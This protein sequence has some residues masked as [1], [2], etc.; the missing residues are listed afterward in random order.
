MLKGLF[1]SRETVRLAFFSP[2]EVAMRKEVSRYERE[3]KL[4]QNSEPKFRAA[5]VGRDTMSSSLLAEMVMRH[6]NCEA[7]NIRSS[8]LL[9][10]LDQSA[11]D[12]VIISAD[13]NSKTGAG[14]S[15]AETI[16]TTY[17]AM[18]IVILIHQPSR[19]ATIS[20]LRA[21]A[22]GLFNDQQALDRLI[23][24]IRYVRSGSIWAGP[25]ETGFLLDAIRE[26]PGL[27][28][29]SDFDTDSL[30]AREMQVVR[31]AASG[32]TNKA[33]ASELHLSE[34]TVKNY[35]FR[36]FEKLG[37][38]NRV[39]LLFYLSTRERPVEQRKKAVG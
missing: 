9:A 6:L 2:G 16:S 7:A 3:L 23:D 18:A 25:E 35:L 36:A 28:V 29:G 13:I 38:S 20:A 5:I 30:S 39:E 22:R 11:I 1:S 8:D 31:A 26:M 4:V 37:V 14:Y 17:P 24:C 27:G 19:D 21:G 15:L 32:K 34:H 12:L 33:I 10:M